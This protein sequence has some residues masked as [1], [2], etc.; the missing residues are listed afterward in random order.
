MPLTYP[1]DRSSQNTSDWLNPDAVTSLLIR[2][3]K[4]VFPKS[5]LYTSDVT[6]WGGNFKIACDFFAG[7][8]LSIDKYHI[9]EF[10]QG[11]MFWCRSNCLK[12]IMQLNLKWT[13]FP[14]EPIGADGSLAHVLER[15]F[16]ILADDIEGFVYSLCNCDSP[17]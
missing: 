9:V 14:E 15:S 10:P 12:R 1:F 17:E 4:F 5:Y 6:N 13:D 8:G 2:D 3:G 16:L 11:T 7:K